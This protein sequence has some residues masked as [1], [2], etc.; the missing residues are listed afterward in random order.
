MHRIRL[1]ACVLALSA[2]GNAAAQD[3]VKVADGKA[4]VLLEND[5]VRVVELT[6]AP[7]ERTAMHSHGDHLVYFLTAAE[8]DE[9]GADGTRQAKKFAPGDVLWLG[10]ITHETVNGGKDTVRTLIVELKDDPG[11]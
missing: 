7:G 1:V 4:R 3:L 11:A 10:P 9:T 8:A 6:S 5:K 2:W